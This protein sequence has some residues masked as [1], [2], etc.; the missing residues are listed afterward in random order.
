MEWSPDSQHILFY[1]SSSI[2]VCVLSMQNGKIICNIGNGNAGC[3]KA[4]W[5]DNEHIITFS[6][7]KVILFF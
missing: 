7:M 3:L 5:A 1:T 2:P 6:E 4:T